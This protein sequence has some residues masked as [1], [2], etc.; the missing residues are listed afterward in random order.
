MLTRETLEGLLKEKET[1]K[2]QLESLYQQNSGQ[3]TLLK[4]MLKKSEES[5]QP[6]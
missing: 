6:K 2:L 5:I 4:D 3:I 1:I